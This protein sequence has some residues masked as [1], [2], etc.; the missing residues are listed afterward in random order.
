MKDCI[1]IIPIYHPDWKWNECLQML[2]KQKEVDFDLYIIDS[3]SERASYEKDLEGLSYRI[4]KTTPQEWVHG[5]LV[6]MAKYQNIG[7]TEEYID[8]VSIS[9]YLYYNVHQFLEPIKEVK[10]ESGA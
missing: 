1:I 8:L 7:E 3:G 2:K 10:I 5:Y 6:V 9:E 4:E